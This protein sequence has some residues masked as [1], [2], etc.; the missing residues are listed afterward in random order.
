MSKNKTAN[1]YKTYY[2]TQRLLTG[3]ACV[4]PKNKSRLLS[5]VKYSIS[6][7]P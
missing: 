5:N 3:T 4:L 7:A 2:L 1:T 6:A